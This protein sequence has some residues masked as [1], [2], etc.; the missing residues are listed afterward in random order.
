MNGSKHHGEATVSTVLDE[1][2]VVV[3]R[4][5]LASRRGVLGYVLAHPIWLVV[6]L[7]ICGFSWASPFFLTGVNIGNVL[8]QCALV[9]LLAVGLTP[10]IISGNIDLTV[11]AVVGFAAC[12][13]IMLQPYGLA[14]AI[15]ATL[16][17]GVLIGLINGL[18]VEGLGISSFI[19]T[20]AGMIGLRGLAFLM[21]GDTS[22]SASDDSLYSLG[23]LALGPIS[24]ITAVFLVSVLVFQWMLKRTVHGRYTYAIGGSRSA[25]RDA[26]VRVSRHIVANFM[27]SGLMAALSGIAMASNLS[28]AAPSYGK[29]YELW[30]VIAVVLGGTRLRGGTGDAIGTFA[31]V[32]ALAVLRNGLNLVHVPPF[33]I[34]VIMGIAL[35]G[36]LLFDRQLNRRRA[37]GE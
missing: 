10:I 13:V 21:A 24:L 23:A 1:H 14:F 32:L 22:I 25:S 11:G 5:L 2:P 19:I 7:L 31:A 28:T 35:I 33:Y 34:P 17:V 4:K 27:L 26:G 15:V 16:G 6:V 30:A 9:G 8:F 36:A 29:D 12:V 3:S 18:L 37:A 20:L